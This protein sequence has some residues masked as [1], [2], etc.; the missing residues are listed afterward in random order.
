MNK[1]EI[2][3]EVKLNSPLMKIGGEAVT[4][5]AV[6]G[7][8]MAFAGSGI[9]S[10]GQIVRDSEG[11]DM[12]FTLK[13]ACELRNVQLVQA[14]ELELSWKS[15]VIAPG[16]MYNSNRFLVSPQPYCPFL[17]T[18]GVSPDG[19][20]MQADVPRLCSDTGYRTELAANAL[21]I[22]AVGIYDPKMNL[23]Y[24][25]GVEVYGN[26]G[27][28]GVNIQTLP[29]EPVRIEICLPVMRKKRYRICDWIDVDNEPGM[30]LE[31]GKTI[32]YKIR[33]IQVKTAAIPEFIAKIAE[34]G[35]ARR[36]QETRRPVMSFADAADLIEAKHDAHNWNETNG[37]YQSSMGN[38]G[39]I[40]QTGWVGG[41]VTFHAMAMS[42][43]PERRSRAVKMLDVF[44]RQAL[45]H[46]GY[47]HGLHDGKQWRSFGVKRPGCRAF[48][49]IR[50]SLECTR[51]VLKTIELL[52]ER[53][54]IIEVAW[55]AAAKRNLD[56]MVDTTNRFGH[57]GYTVDR[58]N[59]DVLWGDSCCGAFGIEPLV[60]GAEWFKEPKYLDTA[61]KLA[62]YYV[63]HFLNN[64]Y[65]C[66]GVGDALMA[67]DSE[68]NYALLSGLVH[69]H[70]VTSE[71]KHLEW[72]RQAADLFATWVLCYDAKLPEDSPL[73]KLGIQARG[74]VF[75][76]VQNQHGAPGI[77]TA[78]GDALLKLYEA[79]GEERY[80][81]LL[82][83]IAQCIPQMIARSGQEQVWGK[84]PP[85]SVSERLMTMDG[86]ERCGHTAEGSTWAEISMLLTARELPPVYRDAKRGVKAVFDVSGLS[87]SG[88]VISHQQSS[89]T[90]FR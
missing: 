74:A 13:S 43:N 45:S 89:G 22:P 61:H 38:T 15:Y 42:D 1:C 85:G 23:G 53:G 5:N 6:C 87:G 35:Y 72:A 56:A 44:C 57:L 83:D 69:L 78:S 14:L 36:G 88:K 70:A 21:T 75:A 26:W 9:T 10:W 76:N 62:D 50:R 68:S 64:G 8:E 11:A 47:F 66:G 20:I 24:L 71:P 7:K 41:G 27:V 54:E 16:V 79:T 25:I 84:I 77:C 48:S 55:E 59:G 82:E 80:L 65:T 31:P 33:V 34:Y 40:M 39:W 90:E 49:L 18:E 12:A 52:K 19:P 73:G 81:R 17:P 3:S 29:D 37:Y 4:L 30:N 63:T 67:V 60:R 51:D 2:F 58:D 46:S 32:S 28:S 86:M